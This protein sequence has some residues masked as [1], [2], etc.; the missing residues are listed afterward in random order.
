MCCEC[1][2]KTNVDDNGRNFIKM[3]DWIK[4]NP[5]HMVVS[6]EKVKLEVVYS[7]DY[8]GL[9]VGGW[10]FYY[11]YEKWVCPHGINEKSEKDCKC[12]EENSCFTA[13]NNG[14]E[15]VR[16]TSLELEANGMRQNDVQAYILMGLGKMIAEKKL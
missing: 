8:I 16:Y 15:I 4:D 7:D 11:G 3:A 6:D 1:G 14:K 13:E 5:N 10:K 12:H 9:D 2:T